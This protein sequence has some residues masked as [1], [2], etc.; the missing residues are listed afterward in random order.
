MSIHFDCCTTYII[1]TKKND[2]SCNS[3]THT[4]THMHILH[5]CALWN[6]LGACAGHV[7]H[8][9]YMRLDHDGVTRMEA[10]QPS[11]P[12]AVP[13]KLKTCIF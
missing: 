4:H 10:C 1:G 6:H 2:F 7:E 11:F 9:G 8:V 5:S 3:Y 13:R 12:E